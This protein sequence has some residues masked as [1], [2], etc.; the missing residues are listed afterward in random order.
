MFV[1]AEQSIYIGVRLQDTLYVMK[2]LNM[3]LSFL[4]EIQPGVSFSN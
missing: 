3:T 2:V 4:L 1:F